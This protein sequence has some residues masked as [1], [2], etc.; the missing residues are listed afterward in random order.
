[1]SDNRP[2]QP[3]EIGVLVNLTPEAVV[4]NGTIV[5]VVRGLQSEIVQG[6]NGMTKGPLPVYLVKTFGYPCPRFR[7]GLW[8]I[9]PH[10]IRRISDPDQAQ[11]TSHQE[12][13]PA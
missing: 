8:G 11:S 10:Q 6:T 12:S 7:G 9:E 5:E 2:L 3:G 4:P 13:A 1:M